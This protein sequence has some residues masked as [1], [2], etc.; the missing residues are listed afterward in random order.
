MD[1]FH[2]ILEK[3]ALDRNDLNLM[4]EKIRVF[5]DHI[6]VQLKADIDS[7]L[8]TGALPEDAANFNWDTENSESQLVGAD[9]SVRLPGRCGHRPLRN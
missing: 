2:D 3:P 8:K 7:L 4:I 9:D 1:V 5:E 6:E